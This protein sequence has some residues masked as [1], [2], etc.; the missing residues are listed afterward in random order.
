MRPERRAL[1]P[2]SRTNS[3]QINKLM[4]TNRLISIVT[5]SLL[6]VILT[7]T[8]C[9]AGGSN[10][11]DPDPPETDTTPPAVPSGLVATSGSGEASL[12]WGAVSSGDLA[13]YNLYRSNTSIGNV[14]GL[15][16]VNGGSLLTTTS[17]TDTGVSNGTTYFYRVTA[18]DDSGNES[19]GSGEVQVTPFP[20]PPDRP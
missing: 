19:G 10:E 17:F 3:S 11:P 6:L 4:H 1:T 2:F 14:E 15:T 12:T 5:A 18:V 9:S 16:P 20:D 13:G 8:G 7:M